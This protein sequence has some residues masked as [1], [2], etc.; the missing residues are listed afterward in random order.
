MLR[1]LYCRKFLPLAADIDLRCFF[2][3]VYVCVYAEL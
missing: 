2:K 1:T 3:R